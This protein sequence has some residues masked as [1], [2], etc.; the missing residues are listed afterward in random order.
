[1][2]S[3]QPPAWPSTEPELSTAGMICPGTVHSEISMS[4]VASA[5]IHRAFSFSEQID[6]HLKLIPEA[7][8][9]PM[10]AKSSAS[11]RQSPCAVWALPLPLALM[12][13]IFVPP[14]WQ[15]P[16]TE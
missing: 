6:A 11:F 3:Q 12:P 15:V 16:F 4:T 1:M 13:R 9:R 8:T 7:L 10:H 14:F 2:R 5:F